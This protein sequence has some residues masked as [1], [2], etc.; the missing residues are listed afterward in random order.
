MLFFDASNVR[1]VLHGQ[2]SARR[3]EEG[4]QAVVR[5]DVEL[6]SAIAW[7][8]FDAKSALTLGKL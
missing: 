7:L 4:S 8:A 5:L 6:Q 2:V 1:V 3:T